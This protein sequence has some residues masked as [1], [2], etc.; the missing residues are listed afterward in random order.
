MTNIT[1]IPW[2]V[3]DFIDKQAATQMINFMLQHPGVEAANFVFMIITRPIW[4]NPTR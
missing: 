3:D 1:I 4:K 2:I